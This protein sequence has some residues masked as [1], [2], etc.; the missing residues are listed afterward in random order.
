[1]ARS[2][3]RKL[4][5][6]G[7]ECAATRRQHRGQSIKGQKSDIRQI[8]IRTLQEE[9]QGVPSE[10]IKRSHIAR[11]NVD[12]ILHALQSQQRPQHPFQA[13]TEKSRQH[14]TEQYG[15]IAREL[16]KLGYKTEAKIMKDFANE[17]SGKSLDTQAQRLY[18]QHNH[19][20]IQPQKEPSKINHHEDGYME[21]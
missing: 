2:L 9:R 15:L 18:D 17:V 19:Q 3:C 12:A 11:A 16:Y 20:A 6:Q 7:V 13:A 1:M 14:I 8:I 4:R 21:R 10:S 5:E